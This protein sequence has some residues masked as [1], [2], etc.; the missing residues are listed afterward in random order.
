MGE[1]LSAT[2]DGRLDGLLTNN[3]RFIGALRT[4]AFGATRRAPLSLPIHLTKKHYAKKIRWGN[5]CA[6]LLVAI[7]HLRSNGL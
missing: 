3:V 6:V 4:G 1:M 7:D 2:E 5:N